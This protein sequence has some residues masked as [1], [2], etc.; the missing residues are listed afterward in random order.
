MQIYLTVPFIRFFGLNEIGVRIVSVLMGL[1]T[2]ITFY[3]LVKEIINQ[4]TAYIAT[5][6]LTFSPWHF[7]YSRQANDAGI[8]LPFIIL[9]TLFFFKGLNNYKYFISSVVVFSLSIYAYAISSLFTPI[10]FL[11]LMVIF[12]R[13]II[14]YG[15]RKILIVGIIG[16]IILCPYLNSIYKGTS[17]KRFSDLRVASYDEIMQEIVD[18]RFWSNSILTRIFYNKRTVYFEK[19]INNYFDA[20][21]STFLFTKSDPNPRQTVSNTGLMYYFDIPLLIIGFVIVFANIFRDKKTK[22]IYF[23]LLLWLIIAPVPSALTRDGG[24]H[25]SR[26][27][28]ILPPLTILSAMGFEFLL[29]TTKTLKMK[30]LMTFLILM[31]T[32]SIMKFLH[33]YFVIWKN[34]SWRFW[35][36]GFK[37]TITFVKNIDSNFE[38]IYFN[39]NYEPMLPRFLF[40]YDYD[41]NLFQEQ[42]TG[43]QSIENVEL[44]FNGFKLGE[45][46]FFGDIPKPVE[47]FAKKDA[48]II[49]S[50]D[51]DITNP[52]IF[53]KSDLIMYKIVSS[54]TNIPIFYIF[55]GN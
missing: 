34:E 17:T 48:L 15:F 6:F 29:K 40:W 46:Y 47:T 31:I 52:N 2:L 39:N 55:S 35:Q 37:D 50:G 8:L 13:K 5:I 7:N 11:S 1:I 44:G 43:D 16:V 26:L 23:I 53:E 30:V 27:I 24:N 3:L 42:F 41:M 9:A 10:Y 33:S 38:R 28:L 25:A 54:P 32:V 18:K 51:K 49:A 21:S 14:R 12:R 22:K 45:K 19:I 20:F 4:K 36:Y